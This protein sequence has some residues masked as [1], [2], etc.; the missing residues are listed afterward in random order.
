MNT[1]AFGERPP[2]C[3]PEIDAVEEYG[4]NWPEDRPFPFTP[5]EAWWLLKGYAVKTRNHEMAFDLYNALPRKLEMSNGYVVLW[6][7]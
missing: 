2:G 4:G 6:R 7:T 5:E 3:P 1:I